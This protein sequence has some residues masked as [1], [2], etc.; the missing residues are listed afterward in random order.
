MLVAR[1]AAAVG[2]ALAAMLMQTAMLLG[3]RFF[4][5]PDARYLFDA[6][7]L[8]AVGI[9]ACAMAGIANGLVFRRNG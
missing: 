5:S 2:V 9:V 4:L 8:L 6:P 1:G 3:A 7:R